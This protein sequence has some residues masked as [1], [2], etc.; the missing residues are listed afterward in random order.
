MSGEAVISI[1]Q[2][3]HYYGSGKLRQH[4]LEDISTEILPG[5]IVI[6]TG[7][8]GSGKT[9]LLTLMGALRSAQQGSL[10]IFG[11]E[12]CGADA[13]SMQSVR[14]Q[15]G[16]IFQAHNLIEALT[17]WQ[18]V[19]MSVYLH[20]DIRRRDARP[21]AQDMLA[22]VGLGDHANKY[23]GELSGGQ[24]QRVGI[25]RALVARPRIL[26]ADEPTASL[27]RHTGRE[28]VDLMRK[29]AHE[30]QVTV[31]IVTHDNRILDVADRILHLEDGR[32]QSLSGAIA[33]NASQLLTM[34]GKHDPEQSHFISTFSH[35]LARVALADNVLAEQERQVMREAM[36]STSG[37]S[38]AEVDLAV[39]LAMAQVRI[40][41]EDTVDLPR[42]PFSRLQREQFVA[43]LYAV[44]NA[45]GDLTEDERQEINRI[46]DELGFPEA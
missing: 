37:L 25:A 10:K 8:S 41:S 12:L 20:P 21:L 44:A 16:Y 18:N 7:P 31:I 6:L 14:R 23:P 27:D 43:A 29:L 17:V 32:M 36:L 2:L 13:R 5:E 30:Q 35:A 1:S 45:D 40:S 34:L 11:R 39:E 26:L 33:E 19:A 9:T 3:E 28:V 15:I 38:Q 42:K 4:I 24:K 22:A 46:A